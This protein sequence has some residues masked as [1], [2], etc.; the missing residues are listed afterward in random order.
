MLWGTY[1][2]SWTVACRISWRLLF[3][4]G[5]EG[6]PQTAVAGTSH[7]ARLFHLL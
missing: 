4:A 5:F 1:H 7:H 2:D 6:V 3:D